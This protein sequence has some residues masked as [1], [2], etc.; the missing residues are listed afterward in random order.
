MAFEHSNHNLLLPVLFT[1]AITLFSAANACNDIGNHIFSPETRQ[2][3]KKRREAEVAQLPLMQNLYHF[4]EGPQVPL[5]YR[6]RFGDSLWSRSPAQVGN[7]TH[8]P[9][10]GGSRPQPA[11]AGADQNLQVGNGGY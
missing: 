10:R 11:A 9:G 7:L 3:S 8:P 5:P 4:R 1:A 6:D 2:E